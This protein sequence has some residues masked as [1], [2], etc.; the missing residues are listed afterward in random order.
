MRGWTLSIGD[1][2]IDSPYT[3]L[4]F[5]PSHDCGQLSGRTQLRAKAHCRHA[6]QTTETIPEPTLF[7]GQPWW[8]VKIV[9]CW[10]TGMYPRTTPATPQSPQSCPYV[11]L[12]SSTWD[13]WLGPFLSSHFSFPFLFP[14]LQLA[15]S[16]IL[17]EKEREEMGNQRAKES[18][19]SKGGT[20]EAS[21]S[22]KTV[23]MTKPNVCLRFRVSTFHLTNVARMVLHF[24]WGWG[25]HAVHPAKGNLL[26][27][28]SH[29]F[30]FV[31][32]KQKKSKTSIYVS[33]PQQLG[34]FLRFVLFW[35]IDKLEVSLKSVQLCNKHSLSLCRGVQA[36][37]I[38]VGKRNVL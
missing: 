8:W 1:S 19:E 11:S 4:I 22:G 15:Q 30:R 5:S 16:E 29:H 26:P 37:C 10:W 9:Q 13:W 2:S 27:F 35:N 25:I 31:P 38:S 12:C 7:W 23:R 3:L 21:S 20:K 6:H 24:L 14:P 18:R 28:W 33:C 36:G 34:N 17:G 32:K